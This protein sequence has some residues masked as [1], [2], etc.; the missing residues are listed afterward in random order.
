MEI[1]KDFERKWNLPNILGALDG[2]HVVIQAPSSE[3]SAYH[4]Y[5]GTHSIVLL[6]LV[7][8]NYKFTYV[9][10]GMNGRVS[11][12]GVYRESDL[13]KSIEKNSLN[14]PED[15]PLPGRQKSVPFV[16]AADAAFPLSTHIL[17][18]YPFRQ[19]TIQQRIFNYRLSRVRRV[20]ENTFGIL[21]NRFRILL[22]TIP[23]RPEKAR[24]I[25]QACVALHNFLREESKAGYI[26]GNLNEDLDRRY[27]FVYG[28]SRQGGNRS[29]V[30]AIATREEF[31]DYVNGVGAVAWQENMI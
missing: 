17:K 22:T 10:I 24:I 18:P 28:L 1:A 31:K 14:F 26:S 23:L 9:N 19:M 21:A 4:N 3:G 30:E 2:K 29:K 5:K 6:A 16:I 12:G 25:V 15:R 7:D 11:D 13:F 20:V 27:R 8:A